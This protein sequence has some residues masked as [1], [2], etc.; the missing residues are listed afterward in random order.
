MMQI[1]PESPNGAAVDG[2]IPQNWEA[3]TPAEHAMWDYL[4]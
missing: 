3:Y 2:T 1:S 4:F